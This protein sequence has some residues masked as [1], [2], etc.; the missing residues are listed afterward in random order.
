M[1]ALIAGGMWWWAVLRMV[2]APGESGPLEGAV[3]VGGWGLSL[4]PVHVVE[5][6]G[7]RSPARRRVR[8]PRSA[9]AWRRGSAAPRSVLTR[10][11]VPRSVVRRSTRAWRRR[12]SGA[13]SDRS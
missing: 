4:L 1:L 9:G 8:S 10:S 5:L 13:G 11:A 7:G 3:A 6:P 12:R 2:L